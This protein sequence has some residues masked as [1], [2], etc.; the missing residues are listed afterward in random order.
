MNKDK[1]ATDWYGLITRFFF[2]MYLSSYY[3]HCAL[4]HHSSKLGASVV[5]PVV[6]LLVLVCFVL[7]KN[8]FSATRD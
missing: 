8:F 7:E 4:R 6:P 1:I 3:L 5:F 2:L